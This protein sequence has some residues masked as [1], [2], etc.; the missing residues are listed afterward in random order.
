MS[1][2]AWLM[3]VSLG[4]FPTPSFAAAVQGRQYWPEPEPTTR[5]PE[6]CLQISLTS[7]TWGIF[8]P[9]L[10]AVNSFSGATQ[11]DIR[12]IAINS[13]TGAEANCTATDVDFGPE[14]SSNQTWHDCSIPDLSFQF[15]LDTLEMRLRG[16][17][18]CDNASKFV[19]LVR[20]I[21]K[22]N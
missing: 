7:P 14:G 10:V 9:T 21:L 22:S 15:T 1:F 8:S 6:E 4:L 13:A 20:N 18:K 12:F 16:S 5:T 2:L 11:G 17:W 3:F 19:F